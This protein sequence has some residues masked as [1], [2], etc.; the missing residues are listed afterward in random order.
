MWRWIIGIC[1]LLAFCDS[2]IGDRY[3]A[4][5][6]YH[7]GSS[8][9]WHIGEPKSREDCTNE[10]IWLYDKLNREKDGRAFSWA[11]LYVHAAQPDRFIGR[12]R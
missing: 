1:L 3:R 10:A 9:R 11:C 2:P 12:V 5:V 4:E 6:G 7:E 8:E